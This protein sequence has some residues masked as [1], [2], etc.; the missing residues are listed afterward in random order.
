M[1]N[2]VVSGSAQYGS[3]C[4]TN[5]TTSGSVCRSVQRATLCG[6]LFLVK[7]DSTG[8][9]GVC[10]CV[11]VRALIADQCDKFINTDFTAMIGF[12][13]F[14]RCGVLGVCGNDLVD[15]LCVCS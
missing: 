13:V 11:C 7:Q 9:R 2:T 1:K 15:V 10:V 6:K 4:G 5:G 3:L 8:A 14:G 12:S